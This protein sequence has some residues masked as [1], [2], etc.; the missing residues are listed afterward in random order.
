[1]TAIKRYVLCGGSGLIGRALALELGNEANEVVIL[2]RTPEKL[3]GLPSNV[4]AAK[5]DAVSG[6]DWYPVAEGCDAIVNLAGTNIGSGK[7]SAE[8]KREIVKSRTDAGRAVVRAVELM[9]EKPRVI[10]QASA[11]GY[12]GYSSATHV[13][14]EYPP[15]NDFLARVAVDWEDSTKPIESMGVRRVIIRTGVVL[16]SNGGVFR[17]IVLPFRLFIGGRLGNGRQPFPWIHIDDE[18]RAIRFLIDRDDVTGPFN[19][20]VPNPVTN[21][22]FSSILA[23]VIKRPNWLPIP[24][25]ALHLIL[26]EMAV[27]ALEGQN[28]IPK[29]LVEKGFI[30]KFPGARQ[31]IEDLLR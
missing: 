21:E 10:V 6:S 17:T 13:D 7:W 3:S 20:T 12:Y 24:A 5:W 1:M 26:G 29:R 9:K 15:G 8:R 16:S 22:Q 18:I 4:R 25:V 23:E 31:A 30:F 19:L 11:V 2:S 27:I 14:E 28:A